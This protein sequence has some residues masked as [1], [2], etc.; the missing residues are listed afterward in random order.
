[1]RAEPEERVAQSEPTPRSM[2]PYII[3]GALV[4]AGIV[5]WLLMSGGEDEPA[6]TTPAPTAAKAPEFSLA[7]DI[8]TVQ[9][10]EPPA[11]EGPP[12]AEVPEEPEP[13]AEEFDKALS[14]SLQSATQSDMFG[15]L[16]QS[17]NLFQRATA[18]IDALS[19]GTVLRK[20]MPLPAVKGDFA[21]LEEDDQPVI[22]TAGY[23]RFDPYVDAVVALDTDMLVAVFHNYRGQFEA[24][25]SALGMQG[26]DFDNALI[27]MLDRVLLTPELTAAIF[28]KQESVMY[29][30]ADP[31]LEALDDLQKQ[32]M[33]M[34]PDN[35]RRIK[36]KARELRRALLQ[37]SPE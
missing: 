25:Y 1:M 20:F 16:L 22:N 7:P 2:T 31:R 4:L 29:T 21:V 28:L 17:N 37:P 33:R 8:P 3:A 24:A 32:L 13:T 34:G 36:T 5:G 10:E 9:P 23:A 19:N 12:V 14:A 30:Y 35:I 11:T 26:E 18:L 27:R 6:P 15:Q